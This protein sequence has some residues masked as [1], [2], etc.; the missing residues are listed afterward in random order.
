MG[1][2]FSRKARDARQERA[3]GA[4]QG[5]SPRSSTA[6]SG[7]KRSRFRDPKCVAH[8][9]SESGA[10]HAHRPAAGRRR[11]ARAREGLQLADRSQAD[12]KP[13]S[14]GRHGPDAHVRSH[15]PQG[16][17]KGVK[18]G[19]LV[20]FSTRL[21]IDAAGRIHENRG[22]V[23]ELML[24]EGLRLRAL[25]TRARSGRDQR[26][27]TMI[28]HVVAPQAGSRAG[29]RRRRRRAAPAA[30]AEPAV[31]KRQDEKAKKSIA[32]GGS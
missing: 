15:R 30:P 16:E 21:E 13:T 6:P 23:S 31:I 5:A 9:H 10:S 19:G 28:V 27:D 22:R 8:L 32:I 7:A 24:H 3:G 17:A 2:T 14:P 1:T 20:D 12:S 4:R 25:Q 18:S 29:V 26:P 11:H